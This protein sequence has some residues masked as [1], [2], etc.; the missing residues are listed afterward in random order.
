MKL[1]LDTHLLLWAAEFE[2]DRKSG[3]SATALLLIRD[4]ANTLCF[5]PASI[6]EVAIKSALKRS[7]F[8]VDA[9]SLR[10]SLLDNAYV[11]LPITSEHAARV[12]L[13]PPIHKDPFDRL[14]IAQAAAEGVTLLTVDA[15]MAEYGGPI[16]RV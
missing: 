11:E 5:S 2:P 3:L 9:S 10:R 1:L 7:D 8:R 15:T 6:W 4:T 16:R 13:L 14:L 12:G